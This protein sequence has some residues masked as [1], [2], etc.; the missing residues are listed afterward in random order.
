M[1]RRFILYLNQIIGLVVSLC[2]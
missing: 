2:I 1:G